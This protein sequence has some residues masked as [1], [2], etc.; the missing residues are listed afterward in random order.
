MFPGAQDLPV[1]FI[2]I[3][4]IIFTRYDSEIL[5]GIV[6][7][8]TAVFGAVV[9][10]TTETAAGSVNSY[11]YYGGCVISDLTSQHGPGR[12]RF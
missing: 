4:K 8:V 6:E 3:I 2:L 10:R 9:L 7:V 1:I 11:Y 5:C 12:R